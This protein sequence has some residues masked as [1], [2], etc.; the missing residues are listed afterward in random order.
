MAQRSA[1]GKGRGDITGLANLDRTELIALWKE[2][3]DK[4]IPKGLST[5]MLLRILS[6]EIQVLHHGGLKAS[7]RR[8]LVQAL[9]GSR[10]AAAQTKTAKTG[11]RL[12]REWNGQTHIVDVKPDG[13]RWQGRH[14]KSLSAIAK[15]ITGTKWSGPRFFGLT[16]KRAAQ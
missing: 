14:Y 2:T 10:K 7:V 13:Y 12:V 11:S 6:W 1:E 9:G 8:K 16:S 4:Q 5:P 15:D 3:F